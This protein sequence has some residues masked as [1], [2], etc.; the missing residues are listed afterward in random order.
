MR[1]QRGALALLVSALMCGCV[2][3][4]SDPGQPAGTGVGDPSGPQQGPGAVEPDEPL[5]VDDVT[6]SELRRLT[7]YEIQNAIAEALGVAAPAALGALPAESRDA[8]FARVAQK[9]VVTDRHLKGLLDA[10]EEL[11]G[12]L[13]PEHMASVTSACADTNLG[14]DGELLAASRKDCV[15]SFFSTVARL[16]FRGAPTEQRSATAMGIYDGAESYAEGLTGAMQ[17]LLQTPEF[18]YALELGTEG[19]ATPGN[20]LALSDLELASRLSFMFCESIP[21]E[22]LLSDAESGRLRD[23]GALEAHAARLFDRCGQAGVARMFFEWLGLADME[24]PVR[25]PVLYAG[26]GAATLDAMLTETEHLIRAAVYEEPTSLKGL[27]SFGSTFA[28][29]DLAAV[30]GSTGLTPTIQRLELP[31]HRKGLL[32]QPSIL[33]R[34]AD[35]QNP[36]PIKRGVFIGRKIACLEIPLPPDN[37]P[38]PPVDQ[39]STRTNRERWFE[40]SAN[41]ACRGCHSLID[42]FGF[43]LEEF[44]AIGRFR[45]TDNGKP[46]DAKTHLPVLDV[47]VENGAGLADALASSPAVADCF[48]RHLL[49]FSLGR[50]ESNFDGTTLTQLSQRTQ[51]QA[52]L[53]DVMTSVAQTYAF[54]HRRVPAEGA[55]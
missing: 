49:R 27:F 23:P 40:H 1:W 28:N 11:A 48:S 3:T 37:V 33:T 42:P 55:L 38:A 32:L 34:Y 44:D 45:D 25:D 54:S 14:P 5:A 15:Q 26:F 18:L 50:M 46:V 30:Y 7:N 13:T 52:A 20:V 10:G 41:A 51:T 29:Q 47:D 39:D 22:A 31:A 4:I 36:A 9:Q 2:G 24:V 8:T 19:K 21:D 53:R 17:Y 43:A 6:P 12:L 35:F 16:A